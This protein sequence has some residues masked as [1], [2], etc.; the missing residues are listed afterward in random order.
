[1]IGALQPIRY[2]ALPLL[3]AF[4][5]IMSTS[6]ARPASAL[7]LLTQFEFRIAPQKLTTALVELSRQA[8]APIV[9][10]TSEVD[11]FDSSGINGRMTLQH[12]LSTLLEGT[13]LQYRVTDQGVIAVGAFVRDSRGQAADTGAGP[14]T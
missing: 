2:P 1:M 6:A 3:I 5:L 13:N 11:R 8:S 10:A 14:G 4:V 9:S 12:A 7:D